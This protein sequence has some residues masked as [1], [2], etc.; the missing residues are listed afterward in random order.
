MSAYAADDA[1]YYE[2]R[3]SFLDAFGGW[4]QVKSESLDPDSLVTALKAGNYYSSTG[5]EFEDI[6]WD[7]ETLQVHSTPVDRYLITATGARSELVFGADMTQATF[8]ATKENGKRAGWADAS[9]F[10]VTAMA[11]DGTSAWSQ[12]YWKN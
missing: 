5:P 10:R 6:S 3:E 8:S 12:P 4:V 7:G 2:P 11:A 9:F 1:H